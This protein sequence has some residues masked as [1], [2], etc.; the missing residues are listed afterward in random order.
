MQIIGQKQVKIALILNK[1]IK[2]LKNVQKN[3]HQSQENY[4]GICINYQVQNCNICQFDGSLCK[5]CKQRWQLLSYQ[6]NCLRSQC[7]TNNY[8]FYNPQTDSCIMNCPET[9]NLNDKTCTSLK[10]MSSVQTISSRQKIV[11]LD[12]SSVIIQSF[13]ELIPQSQIA[14][15]NRFDV[16]TKDGKN[17]FL[18]Q[19]YNVQRIDLA[20]QYI[21]IINQTVDSIKI[22]LQ[23]E[24]IS[25][26]NNYLNLSL[27]QFSSGQIL[28]YQIQNQFYVDFDPFPFNHQDGSDN[29][30]EGNTPNQPDSPQENPKQ[31]QV[32]TMSDNQECLLINNTQQLNAPFLKKQIQY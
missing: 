28:K 19:D 23:N 2:V 12:S 9:K 4:F 27:F 25:F 15:I 1:R 31:P 21:Q 16:V 22:F 10:K 18:I 11:V 32:Q 6:K 26:S 7:L 20:L 14:Y 5:Q 24:C 13:P 8:S 17:I 29:N 3:A 30:D